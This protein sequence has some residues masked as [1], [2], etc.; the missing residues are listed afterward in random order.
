[1]FGTDIGDLGRERPS[2]E[3]HRMNLLVLEL[4]KTAPIFKI[5]FF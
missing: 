3:S 2:L 5:R 4:M 1:M